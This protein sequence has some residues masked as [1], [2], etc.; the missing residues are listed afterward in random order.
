[1]LILCRTVYILMLRGRH[2][3]EFYIQGEPNTTQH[4]AWQEI[5]LKFCSGCLCV[6]QLGHIFIVNGFIVLLKWHNVHVEKFKQCRKHKES[7]KTA[8]DPITQ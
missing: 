5:Y 1:M 8:T 2:V 4:R 7:C 6:V 3:S